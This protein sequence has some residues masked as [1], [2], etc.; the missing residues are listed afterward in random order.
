MRLQP[1][2]VAA[3]VAL[4]C[5]LYLFQVTQ[6]QAWQQAEMHLS[7]TI[8]GIKHQLKHNNYNLEKISAHIGSLD[9][10]QF[11]RISIIDP[12]GNVLADNHGDVD[13]MDNH[14]LRPE[15]KAALKSETHIGTGVRRSRT[16]GLNYLYMAEAIMLNQQSICIVRLGMPSDAVTS[17]SLS[18]FF[19]VSLPVFILIAGITLYWYVKPSVNVQTM[20]PNDSAALPYRKT[21][22]ETNETER[23]IWQKDR[24]FNLPAMLNSL[25]EGIIAVNKNEKVVYL[26]KAAALILRCQI[27]EALGRSIWDLSRINIIPETVHQCISDP[28]E[29]SCEFQ[30]LHNVRDVHYA[31]HITPIFTTDDQSEQE[32]YAAVAIIDDISDQQRLEGIRRNFFTN[33]SHELKTPLAVIRGVVETMIDDQEMPP[34]QRNIFLEK[35]MSQCLRLSTLVGDILT[36][37]RLED[38]EDLKEREQLSITGV[39]R[40]CVRNLQSRAEQKQISV[41]VQLPE[42]ACAIAG[43]RELMQ[44][45]FDNLI[46]NAINYSPAESNVTA[47]LE[48]KPEWYQVSVTDNGPGIPPHALERIFERFYR[49]DKAR[50]R[51]VGGTGLGL[52]IAK[53]AVALHGGRISVQ[54]E[55]SK[56]STFIVQLPKQQLVS[57]SDEQSE[58]SDSQ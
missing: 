3:V 33:V 4:I 1:L 35:A 51:Q 48:V 20:P 30:V 10:A 26:N 2:I 28:V 37:A 32:I 29:R 13:L 27:D 12:S 38:L 58:S 18:R 17:G 53:H 54:S 46:S 31:L 52:S 50:S 55:I 44:Q 39:L 15:I 21:R 25:N 56:G 9:D 41:D 42:E 6:Q 14:S 19:A 57:E 5:G 8:Q 45:V 22:S 16:T 7:Q 24:A 40:E 47:K 49:V 23:V 11:L 43:D 36:I 34:K